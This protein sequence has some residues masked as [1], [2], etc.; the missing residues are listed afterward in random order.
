M[1]H[2]SYILFWITM[3]VAQNADIDFYDPITRSNN[4]KKRCI[5]L[6]KN[7]C[8]N[9]DKT[10]GKCCTKDEKCEKYTRCSEDNPDAPK[11]FKYMAC[12]NE[13]ICGT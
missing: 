9:K 1:F 12:P 11:W 2:L 3:V 6:D 10:G 5:D 13:V 8:I 7:Y 4:C